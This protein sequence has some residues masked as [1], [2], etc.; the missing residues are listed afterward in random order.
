MFTRL[1]WSI[2]RDSRIA[3]LPRV[4]Q[5]A[6]LLLRNLN[7]K[8]WIA[9]LKTYHHRAD[10]IATRHNVDFMH[11]ERFQKAYR[12]AVA[13]SG[14]DYGIPFRVH[15]ALWCSRQAQKVEGDFVEL[16]TG[17]GFMMSAVLADFHNWETA[18][19]SLHLFDI[20][21]DDSSKKN[22]SQSVYTKSVEDVVANFSEW[23]RVKIHH[24][25]IFDTLSKTII[26]SVAFLHIDMNRPD[27][28][29]YGLRTLWDRLSRGGVVLLDD[30][31]YEGYEPQYKA[32]ND[33]S[34][35]IGF[36]ILTTAT[37]QGIIIK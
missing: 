19:R 22:N 14:W 24:G 11:E 10:G 12:R 25:D 30:Y 4:A 6:A 9:P 21:K 8:N 16:G 35:E 20:F 32:M 13:A 34:R 23:T 27:P 36:D 37:G 18:Q 17:R 7:S 28:E 5:P 3:R 29:I 1:D 2:H 15:Q 33:L 26:G 31:A